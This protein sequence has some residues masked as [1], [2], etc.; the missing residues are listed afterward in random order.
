L[1]EVCK[2]L[3]EKV[4]F[5]ANW[6]EVIGFIFSVATFFVVLF[7]DKKIVH[8][9]K[10]HLLKTRI[11]EHIEDLKQI[12][13]KTTHLL[14]DDSQRKTLLRAE[15]TKSENQLKSLKKIIS[16]KVDLSETKTCLRKITKIGSRSVNVSGFKK[17]FNVK[18][19]D[20]SDAEEFYI[21]LT[22]YIT[23]LENLRKDNL[24]T[25]I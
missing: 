8:F 12:S 25:M 13:I 14:T 20:Q 18:E 2:I 7:V 16:G 11:D 3:N 22:G 1:N 15:I 6:L 24:N 19:F 9:N 10:R 5:L 21:I 4:T 17:I 23:Y